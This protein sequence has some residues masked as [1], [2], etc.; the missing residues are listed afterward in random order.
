MKKVLSALILVSVFS[1]CARERLIYVARHCQAGGKNSKVIMPVPGDAGISQLGIEQSKALGRRLKA[2]GFKGKI[3][4]SPYFRTVATACYAAAECGAK[5]YPDARVQERVHADGGN[6][7][8]G[9]ATLKRLRELF[10]EQIADDAKLDDAWLYKKEEKK[11]TQAH[12]KRMAKS[13]D[14]LLAENPDSDIMIVSHAGAVGA[15]SKEIQ[16][17]SKHKFY[18]PTWNCALF[19]YSVDDNGKFHVKAYDISFLP[20]NMITNNF[21]RLSPEEKSSTK[22]IQ[23]GID[24][25]Y[26]L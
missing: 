26:N 25:K 13:L 3:Y 7:K 6:M 5:V 22:K 14:L 9:G 11:N 21:R 1:L 23:S 16:S 20:E 17:R 10:P 18:G 15:L 12:R 8:T 2:L 24:H 4:A 19:R